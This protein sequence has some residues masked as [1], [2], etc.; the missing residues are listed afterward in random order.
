MLLLLVFHL[1]LK[2]LSQRAGF[3]RLRPVGLLLALSLAVRLLGAFLSGA[4]FALVAVG[5]LETLRARP[6]VGQSEWIE[7]GRNLRQ[8]LLVRRVDQ[9]HDEKEGHH[10][11]HE[12]GVGDLPYTAMVFRLVVVRP[13]ADDDELVRL[14]FFAAAHFIASSIRVI[15]APIRVS[16]TVCPTVTRR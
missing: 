7:V 8:R 2:G 6:F 10:R 3:A 4:V 13:A 5:L 15:Q 16:K 12:V 9:P 1:A 11:R 14:A